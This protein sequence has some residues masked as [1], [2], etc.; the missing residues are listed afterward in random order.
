MVCEEVEWGVALSNVPLV[1]DLRALMVCCV[2]WLMT[3]EVVAVSLWWTVHAIDIRRRRGGSFV[4]QANPRLN[5]TV[6]LNGQQALLRSI[7]QC[8]TTTLCNK[9]K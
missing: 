2:L 3:M 5:S 1:C 8:D 6:S 7:C 4:G 9:A